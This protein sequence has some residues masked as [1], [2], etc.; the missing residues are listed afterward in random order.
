MKD[1]QLIGEQ[2]GRPEVLWSLPPPAPPDAIIPLCRELRIPPLIASV[3]W[4]RGFK[5]KAAEDLYPKLTPCPL[6]GIEEAVDLIQLTLQSHKR[7]LIHGDY[8]ADGISATAILKLGL[9][10]LGGNVQIH[11]PNRL[12]EGYGIH[13]DRVEEHILRADLII[14]VDCGISNISPA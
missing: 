7:I 1:P 4:T 2:A 13:L 5:E 3:L 6:P 10:E 11:I 12:T 8:D 14:T 9:E